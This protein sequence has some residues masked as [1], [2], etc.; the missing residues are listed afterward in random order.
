MRVVGTDVGAGAV[1]GNNSTVRMDFH[2]QRKDWQGIADFVYSNSLDHAWSPLRAVR[3]WMDTVAPHGALF[4]EHDFFHTV[5]GVN[6]GVDIF[7]ATWAEY[8]A[9]VAHAGFFHVAEVL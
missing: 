8:V 1:V 4:I 3:A 7:G 9:M 5:T 2:D 6:G